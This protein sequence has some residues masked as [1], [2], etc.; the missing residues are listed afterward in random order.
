MLIIAGFAVLALIFCLP[1]LEGKVLR[2][3]DTMNWKAMYQETKS[4][5]DSTGINPLWTNC[6]FGGM[7]NYTIGVPESQNYVSGIQ[8]AVTNI[9]AKPAYFFFIAM[10]CFYILM[11]IMRTDR[12]LAIIGAFAYAFSTNNV[13]IIGAGHDTKMLALS[14]LPAVLAGLI[15]LYRGRWVAGAALLGVALALMVGANHFQVVYYAM[16]TIGVYVLAKLII[17]LYRKE[18]L[19]QFFLSSVIAAVVAGIGIGPSMASILTTKE[20]VKTTMRGGES[21]LTINHDSNKKSGGLDKDYAFT[22]SNGIGETFSL[23][24][25]Y[26]YGG[27]VSEPVDKA[28]ETEALVGGQA[29]QLPLYWGPQDMG[30]AGPQY[31]GAIICFLFVL[32]MMV[33]KSPHKWWIFGISLFMIMLSW[34]DHFKAFNYFIFDHLPMY[35]KFRAPTQSII[36]PQLFFPLLGIWGLMEII[37]GK[38]AGDELLKQLKIAA[39]ITAGLCVLLGL[40]GSMFFDYTNPAIDKQL[41]EQ[42][43]PALKSDRA[44]LATKSALTSAVYIL[45]AAGLIWGFVKSKLNK[46]ILIAGIGLLIAIDLFSVDHNYLNEDNYVDDTEYEAAFQPRPVD[47]QILQDKDPYYRV[48]DLSV[49]TYNDAIQ[50]Y[51]HKCIGGYS[52][53]KMEIYQDLIDMQMGG[54]HAQ[55]KFNTEVLNMLNTKY[56][57]FNGGPQRQPVYQPLP[58][59]CGNAWFVDEVKWVQTADEEMTALNAAALGDTA[60]VP[61]GFRPKHT[62]IIRNS[63]QQELSG[64]NF[65]KDSTAGIR[66]TRYGLNNLWFESNNSVN[67]LAVFSD[68]WYPYGWKAFIDGKET[69]IMRADYVLR[70]IKIPQGKHQVEFRFEPASYRTGS[71]I[72]MISSFL[73]I[74]LIL[75]GIYFAVRKGKAPETKEPEELL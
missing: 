43:L 38:V 24:I 62:A 17:T 64:Y 20:Y 73:L 59:A 7:P 28:P 25:P 40:G 36:I 22:W 11:S 6:M 29:S 13:V 45:I 27:S 69:P 52:P 47:L 9:L 57:I 8:I 60:A 74:G 3:G 61:G 55:G 72:A 35:N 12:W 18:N 42:L 39:G 31:L 2:Q 34:G 21:E 48:L 46:N 4:Y 58:G 32:G 50:A 10:V 37:K 75:A 70:A 67:G 68:I 44:A 56:I 16:I 41:P 23:M 15:V 65:G 1:V 14:Y 30:I 51:W 49:N 66:L 19:K 26:L 54:A 63:F 33:V 5:H 53:A 71:K